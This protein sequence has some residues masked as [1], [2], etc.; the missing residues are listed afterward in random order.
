MIEFSEEEKAV[1]VQK[2]QSYFDKSLDMELGQFDAEF[3]LQ[4]FAEEVGA[5]FYNQGLAD[6]QAALASRVDLIQDAIYEL[7]KPTEFVR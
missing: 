3:V 1:L 6:A 2:I 7:E 4:F 5:Y